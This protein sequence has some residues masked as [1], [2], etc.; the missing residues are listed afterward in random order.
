MLLGLGA[1]LYLASCGSGDSATRIDALGAVKAGDAWNPG[2]RF[3]RG[4]AV[5]AV[6]CGSKMYFGR[7]ASQGLCLA[8][9]DLVVLRSRVHQFNLKVESGRVVEM[10]RYPMGMDF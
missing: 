7:E 2:A 10:T 5:F 9:P 6:Q 3:P 1:A 4:V 8:A